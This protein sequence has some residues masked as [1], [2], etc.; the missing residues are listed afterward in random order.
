MCAGTLYRA[1][2]GHVVYGM[3]ESRLLE[4]TGNHPQ[5]PTMSLPAEEVFARGQK[6][7]TLTG[8]FDETEQETQQL[9]QEFWKQR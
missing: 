6:S 1:N 7:I 4:C 3:S 2:I 8:P 5:N 9:Q